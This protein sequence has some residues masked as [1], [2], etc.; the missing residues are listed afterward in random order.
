[1]NLEDK[2]VVSVRGMWLV[3]N[4]EQLK[5]DNRLTYAI[6][7]SLSW[8]EQKTGKGQKQFTD[9]VGGLTGQFKSMVRCRR[10]TGS[11]S[12]CISEPDRK[13]C[14]QLTDPLGGL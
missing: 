3:Q 12:C 4:K 6:A 11:Q 9:S 5:E 14:N 2:L 10:K 1:M 8:F 13:A 7:A